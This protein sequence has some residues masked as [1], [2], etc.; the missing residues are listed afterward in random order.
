MNVV[1][2][3]VHQAVKGV[4]EFFCLFFYLFLVASVAEVFLFRDGQLEVS[5][6]KKLLHCL[7]HFIGR[8]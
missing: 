3:V 6:L 8:S 7:F 2:I 4:P 5:T 1:A